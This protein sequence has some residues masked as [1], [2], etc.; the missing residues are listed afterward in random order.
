MSEGS[1][2]LS[3]S[4]YPYSV[5]AC[6]FGR[7]QT[8]ERDGVRVWL[9]CMRQISLSKLAARV[10]RNGKVKHDAN[11]ILP[12]VRDAFAGKRAPRPVHAVR[13]GSRTGH[14]PREQPG[15]VDRSP[16][17]RGWTAAVATDHGGHP[18]GIVR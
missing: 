6:A 18:A 16:H 10:L 13:L 5:V 12:R 17:R 15:S 2:Q 9:S 11:Q 7:S 3:I 14:D 8:D 1:S 4:F